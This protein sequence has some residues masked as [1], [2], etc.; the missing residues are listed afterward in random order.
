MHNDSIAVSIAPR[1][2]GEVRPYGIIGG[3]HADAF[4]LIKKLGAVHPGASL[5][6]CYEAGPRGLA[7]CRC[8]RSTDWTVCSTSGYGSSEVIH[9]LEASPAESSRQD[10]A[11]VWREV[12][13]CVLHGL[14]YC[15]CLPDFS[16]GEASGNEFLFNQP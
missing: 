11:C 13:L 1:E 15:L 4:K 6:F 3:E 7:L 12:V 2:A 8:L 10:L 5:R 16:V 14:E 9:G